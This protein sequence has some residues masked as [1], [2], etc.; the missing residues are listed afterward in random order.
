V[1]VASF[2]TRSFFGEA[3]RDRGVKKR[4]EECVKKPRGP[5]VTVREAQ[6]RILYPR[7]V[8]GVQLYPDPSPERPPP[9][10]GGTRTCHFR[11]TVC[12]LKI[13]RIKCCG[14]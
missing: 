3:E 11:I 5:K 9:R 4:C 8:P 6:K 14:R 1:F 12:G 13:Y 10:G 7:M 2:E